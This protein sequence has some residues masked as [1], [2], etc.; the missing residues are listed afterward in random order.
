[1]KLS[2]T[3]LIKWWL[4]KIIIQ[5]IFRNAT[6]LFENYLINNTDR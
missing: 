5:L 3:T 2:K 4:A 1:M 6:P